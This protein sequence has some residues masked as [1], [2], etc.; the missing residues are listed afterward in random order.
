MR[1]IISFKTVKRRSQSINIKIIYTICHDVASRGA[2]SQSVTVNSTGCGFDP[3][4]KNE[5]FIYIYIIISSLWCRG[6]ARRWVPPLNTQHLQNLAKSGQRKVLTLG[7]FCLH[8]C[9]RDTAW[10][11]FMY[12]FVIRKGNIESYIKLHSH[13]F[14]INFR[15]DK[16]NSCNY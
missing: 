8:C 16:L 14:P 2:G 3:H 13:T 9:V 11:W 12:V 1:I 6:K 10:S 15:N 7:S 5:I 4:S